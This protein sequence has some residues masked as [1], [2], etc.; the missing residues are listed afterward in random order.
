MQIYRQLVIR[1]QQTT[2]V[3]GFNSPPAT[4]FS[5]YLSKLSEGGVSTTS[6]RNAFLQTKDTQHL[7]VGTQTLNFGTG[8]SVSLYLVQRRPI[9][10][11]RTISTGGIPGFCKSREEDK[12][13]NP[14]SPTT[15]PHGENLLQSRIAEETKTDACFL[16]KM[17]SSGQTPGQDAE[18]HQHHGHTGTYNGGRLLVY[19]CPRF[20]AAHLRAC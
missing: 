5:L 12:K 15:T 7:D 14:V 18:P 13:K 19:Y 9:L 20:A 16:I 8:R 10:G 11:S 2:M 4:R 1:T 6:D 17:C 3:W